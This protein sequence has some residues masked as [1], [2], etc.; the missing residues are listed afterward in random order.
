MNQKLPIPQTPPLGII[1]L[2]ILTTVVA[3]CFGIQEFFHYLLSI[4]GLVLPDS[5]IGLWFP[6]AIIQGSW[7]AGLIFLF[8][9]FRHTGRF[10]YQP[11]HWI[12]L[13]RSINIPFMLI[14]HAIQCWKAAMN[15]ESIFDINDWDIISQL[16]LA[17]MPI[18]VQ[19]CAIRQAR[20]E[21][22]IRWLFSSYFS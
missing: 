5:D 10:L 18:T 14:V 12:I 3:S 22:P 15:G 4:S 9:N 16:L 2:L 7:L 17:A 19:I 20:K 1:H 8:M 13:S 11:G 21:F 6:Q